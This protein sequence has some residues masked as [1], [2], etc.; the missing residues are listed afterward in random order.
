MIEKIQ[1][2]EN[3]QN[4]MNK[5]IIEFLQND[6]PDEDFDD[7]WESQQQENDKEESLGSNYS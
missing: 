7:M 5:D 4:K 6:I 2:E 3:W 1:K